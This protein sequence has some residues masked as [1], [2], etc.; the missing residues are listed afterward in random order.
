M[1]CKTSCFNPS[2]SKNDLRRFW[3]LPVCSFF[4]FLCTLVLP[5]YRYLG[6]ETAGMLPHVILPPNMSGRFCCWQS[7]HWYRRCCCSS[8]FTAKRRF[9]ST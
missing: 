2:L 1:K 6:D 7:L 9:N 3:P 8:I 4:L 5:L